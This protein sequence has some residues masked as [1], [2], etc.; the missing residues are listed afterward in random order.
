MNIDIDKLIDGYYESDIHQYYKKHG[1]SKATHFANLKKWAKTGGFRKQMKL[2][3]YSKER[4]EKTKKTLKERGFSYRKASLKGAE[5]MKNMSPEMRKEYADR[6]SKI[7]KGKK[8]SDEV[9]RNISLACIGRPSPRKNKTH[10]TESKERMSKSAKV[11]VFTQKH[12]DNIGK[13]VSGD[14]NPFYGKKHTQETLQI[15]KDKHPS[16]IKVTCEHCYKELDL[17]NYKRYHGEK[18]KSINFDRY[19]EKFLLSER[20]LK[21]IDLLDKKKTYKEITLLTGYSKNTIIKTN[22]LHKDY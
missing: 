9:K 17:P 21:I 18:C 10:T 15:I 22:R 12:R 1:E 16:K 4:V 20:S 5:K 13:A 8:R 6:A 3:S 2:D 14:K 11:K 19:V 7:H